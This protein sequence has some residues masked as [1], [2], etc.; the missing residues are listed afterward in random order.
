MRLA[1]QRKLTQRQL[2][3]LKLICRDELTNRAVALSLGISVKTVQQHR[4]ALN[5]FAGVHCPIGLYKWAILNGHVQ[6]PQKSLLT[7]A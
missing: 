5:S 7:A 1:D 2:E 3:V 6:A 4:G